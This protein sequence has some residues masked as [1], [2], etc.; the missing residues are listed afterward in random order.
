MTL[1]RDLIYPRVTGALAAAKALSAVD[2]PG[3][4]GQLREILIRDLL[5]PLLPADIGIGTGVVITVDAGQSSQQDIV[6]YDRSILPPILMEQ[7]TGIFPIESVLFSIEVKSVLNAAELRKSDENAGAID[8]F[9]YLSGTY[10]PGDI[11][12]PQKCI[13]LIPAMFAF[14][15]DLDGRGKTEIDR[16]DEIR[17]GGTPAMKSI[18]VV[19]RGNWY[20]EELNGVGGWQAAIT[21]GP[22]GEV[23]GFLAGIINTYPRIA[24]S[25]CRPRLGHYL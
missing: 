25:R 19:G 11:P 9:T 17:G 5:R 23:M 10:D 3:L 16:Y 6:I 24:E 8:Q 21:Q 7:T 2:H 15:S 4:K 22:V 1:Y 12:Q 18:C 14:E 13:H 20:W